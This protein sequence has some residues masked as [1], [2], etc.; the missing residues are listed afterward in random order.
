MNCIE[1]I[2]VKTICNISWEEQ[3]Q[4]QNPLVTLRDKAGAL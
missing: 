2:Y 3:K 1:A 4:Q